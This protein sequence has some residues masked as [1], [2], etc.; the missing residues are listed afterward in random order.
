M[1]IE[2]KKRLI[3]EDDLVDACRRCIKSDFHGCDGCCPCQDA[4]LCDPIWKEFHDDC[5]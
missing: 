1:M 5:D 2:P 3:T 4:G